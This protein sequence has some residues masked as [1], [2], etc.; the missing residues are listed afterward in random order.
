MD[1]Q[2]FLTL[3]STSQWI[4]FLGIGLIIYS[5]TKK[6]QLFQQLGQGTFVVLALFAL[7]VIL[8]DQITV[9]EITNGQEPP[10]EAKALTYFSGLVIAGVIAIVGFVL[11]LKKSSWA[12]FPNLF[13]VGGGLALFFMVYELQRL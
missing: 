8:G 12:K 6:K 4:L 2:A 9:P 1:R 5:W 7:W 13:L 10:V 11:G 3:T